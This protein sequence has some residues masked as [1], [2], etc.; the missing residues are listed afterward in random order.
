MVCLMSHTIQTNNKW[1]ILSLDLDC[2]PK[3][4]ALEGAYPINIETNQP[5][6]VKA[7]YSDPFQD[8]FG[9]NIIVHII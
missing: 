6:R 4:Q 2:H 1:S 5:W 3:F 7:H 9:F 8:T